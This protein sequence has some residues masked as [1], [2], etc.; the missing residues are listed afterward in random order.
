MI[1]K[2]VNYQK[3]FLTLK[4]YQKVTPKAK[5]LETF[6]CRAFFR[7][8]IHGVQRRALEQIKIQQCKKNNATAVQCRALAQINM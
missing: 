3:V 4:I 2:L 7:A 8:K 6:G 1:P 5:H